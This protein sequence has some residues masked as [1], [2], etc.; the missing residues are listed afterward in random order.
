MLDSITACLASPASRAGLVQR[1]SDTLYPDHHPSPSMLLVSHCLGSIPPGYIVRT[2]RNSAVMGISY[3]YLSLPA[4]AT[5]CIETLL[6]HLGFPRTRVAKTARPVRRDGCPPILGLSRRQLFG[7]LPTDPLVMA[8]SSL[9]RG[10]VF[11]IIQSA[12]SPLPP[13]CTYAGSIA[14]KDQRGQ[15]RAP[16]LIYGGFS[17][18]IR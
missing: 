1:G 16:A 10:Y 12:T 6:Q 17:R 14:K 5:A 9:S 7:F 11:E 4:H 8:A 18:E 15:S 3:H 2:M 13:T